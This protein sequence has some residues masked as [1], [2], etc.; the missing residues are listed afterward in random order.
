[1]ASSSAQAL[2][3][4]KVKNNLENFAFVI[5][6]VLIFT[7]FYIFPFVE[8]FNLSLHEWNGIDQTRAFVGLRNFA[9]LM[10]DEIWWKSLGNASYIT[11]IALTFQNALAFALALACDREIK[12]RRFY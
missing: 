7:I 2:N 11:M 1:M 8:I 10:H 4:S 3:L 5:P 12:M 6:A 9:E